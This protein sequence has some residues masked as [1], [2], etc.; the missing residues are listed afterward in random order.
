MAQC[1]RIPC[2]QVGLDGPYPRTALRA[3]QY[4]RQ[5]VRSHC[6]RHAH[7]VPARPLPGYRRGPAPGSAECRARGQI[8]SDATATDRHT[9][10]HGVADERNIMALT[11][12]VF[13]DKDGTVL[14]DV[15]YN[16]GPQKMEFAPGAR[17]GL[18][19]LGRLGAALFIIS[20]QPGVALGYFAPFA[21]EAVHERLRAMFRE[22]GAELHGFFYCPH[23]P[24]GKVGAYTRTCTCRKPAP[25]MLMTAAK[26]HQLDL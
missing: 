26:R 19:G 21:L 23:H 1:Q 4:G 12:A 18:E 9:G 24:D 13:L 16:I 20:N 15:P 6:G 10:S 25:G 2:K 5:G 8:R 7:S 3:A 11:P 14:Q 17:E 22:E